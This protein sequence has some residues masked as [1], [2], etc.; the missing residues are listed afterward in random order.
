MAIERGRAW[1]G[2]STPFRVSARSAWTAYGNSSSTMT[3]ESGPVLP[4]D[5][6]CAATM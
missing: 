1:I 6:V 2:G 3:L 4:V 5:A